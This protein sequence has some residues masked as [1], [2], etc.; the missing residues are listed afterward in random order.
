V[1]DPGLALRIAADIES[2][3]LQTRAGLIALVVL[4]GLE[5]V[6]QVCLL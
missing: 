3:G 2:G 6:D 5:Q 1:L 4:K